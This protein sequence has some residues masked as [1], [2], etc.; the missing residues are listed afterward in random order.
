MD[1][2][3]QLLP[4]WTGG[5]GAPWPAPGRALPEHERP[6]DGPVMMV[7]QRKAS[8]ATAEGRALALPNRAAGEEAIVP[9]AERLFDD[10][11]ASVLTK[12]QREV[13]V[14]IAEGA[15]NREIAARLGLR[16]HTVSHHVAQILWRLG[17]TDRIHVAV[18]A[19]QQG[20][21]RPTAPT[22]AGRQG[23]G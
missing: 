18:W 8:Q 6:P 14:L 5:P 17:T 22:T 11:P 4:G 9:P 12:R 23:E 15:S 16:R 19:A 2:A 3:V 1:E 20:L 13:A 7:S 21:Y 10:V